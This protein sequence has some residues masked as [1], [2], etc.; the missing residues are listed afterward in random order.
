MKQE[1]IEIQNLKCGGC[2]NS[3][4]QTMGLFPEVTD[5]K[6][7]LE[8]SLVSI[9]TN[10]DDQ[11]SKYEQALIRAGYPPVGVD[12]PLHRKAKSYVS[13]AIGRVTK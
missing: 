11:R 4:L 5:V 9:S 7:D 13:C 10:A 8:K 1:L 6:V 3:I 2:V 12:N